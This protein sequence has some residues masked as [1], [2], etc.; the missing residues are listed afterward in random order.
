M[1]AEQR[2]FFISRDGWYGE[3]GTSPGQSVGVAPAE[4]RWLFEGQMQ[5]Q[6]SATADAEIKP[7]QSAIQRYLRPGVLPYNLLV[8]SAPPAQL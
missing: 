3:A 4:R 5:E 6:F 2:P 8:F 7:D 1:A